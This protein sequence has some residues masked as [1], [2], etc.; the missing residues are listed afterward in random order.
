LDNEHRTRL[1]QFVTGTCRL[2]V[3]GFSQLTGYI[4]C[5]CLSACEKDMDALD[6]RPGTGF[7]FIRVCV[8][9]FLV[10]PAAQNFWLNLQILPDFSLAAVTSTIYG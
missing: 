10:N 4:H 2:P 3:G 1:L 9:P 8:W 7:I 5:P 6:F